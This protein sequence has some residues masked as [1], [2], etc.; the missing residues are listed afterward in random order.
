V[1]TQAAAQ[2]VCIHAPDLAGLTALPRLSRI[3]FRFL[4][5]GETMAD[6][7]AICRPISSD[8]LRTSRAVSSALAAAV[9]LSGCPAG[10]TVANGGKMLRPALLLLVA[11]IFKADRDLAV[12]LAAAVELVHVASLIHDDVI[13]GAE[14]RRGLPA[15][16]ARI[17]AADAVLLGDVIFTGV[18]NDIVSL[19]R[20]DLTGELARTAREV[21]AGEVRQNRAKGNFAATRRQYLTTAGL[22]TASLYRA[23]AVM[24]ALAGAAP[25]RQVSAAARLGRNFGLAFQ[26]ADDLLDVAGDPAKTGKPCGGDLAQGKVTLPLIICLRA[27]APS[28]RRMLREKLSR[29]DPSGEVHQA[30][31]AELRRPRIVR[32]VRAAARQYSLRAVAEL[33]R[34]PKAAGK[35]NLEALCRFAVKR[36]Y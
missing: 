9:R 4:P 26:I 1:K 2:K 7:D 3:V 11:R 5:A 12:R 19:G 31:L 36:Q 10:A 8:L 35:R 27:L 34:L 20:S 6:L 15:T 16:C 28:R 33:A 21:C 32:T 29:P 18:F 17:G 24:A 14:T 25:R 23:C 22:K 30:V 13:D